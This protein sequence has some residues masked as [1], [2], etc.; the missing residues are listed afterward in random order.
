MIEAFLVA[1]RTNEDLQRQL[2]SA[3]TAADLAAVGAQAGL[4]IE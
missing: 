1:I 4:T 2:R 3:T